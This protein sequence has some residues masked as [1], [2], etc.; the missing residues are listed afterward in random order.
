MSLRCPRYAPVAA[1]KHRCQCPAAYSQG[2]G[3]G[4]L[5]AHNDSWCQSN[6]WAGHFGWFSSGP[7][8]QTIAFST[9]CRVDGKR[10]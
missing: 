1:G 9:A 6:Q 2:A 4:F 5:V 3:S 10:V 7:Q 8:L